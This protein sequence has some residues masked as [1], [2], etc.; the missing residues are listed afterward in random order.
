[1]AIDR[2]LLLSLCIAA[3]LSA[4]PA[5]ADGVTDF[6]KST[7]VSIVVGQAAGGGYDTYAR[8]MARHMPR[9]MPGRFPECRQ[10]C[11]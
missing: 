11:L 8:A 9:L 6:Y 10:L 3:N 1:M 5:A 4:M 7:S 2:K